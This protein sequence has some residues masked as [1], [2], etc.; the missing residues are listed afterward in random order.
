M[1]RIDVLLLLLQ[2]IFGAGHYGRS[3]LGKITWRAQ[4][5]FAKEGTGYLVDLGTVMQVSDTRLCLR[6]GNR[7][8]IVIFPNTDLTL[9]YN[10]TYILETSIF[11]TR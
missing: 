9:V 4:I 2:T 1:K 8:C 3:R 5:K 10:V 7:N 6:L 11:F